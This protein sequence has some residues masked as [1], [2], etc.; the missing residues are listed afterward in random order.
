[1]TE[2]FFA[3]ILAMESCFLLSGGFQVLDF[4]YRLHQVYADHPFF[5]RYSFAMV[6]FKYFSTISD[7]IGAA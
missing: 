2:S 5:E 1:M 7:A 3:F 6:S 4:R